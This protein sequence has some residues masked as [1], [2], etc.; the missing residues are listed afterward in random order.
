M[1]GL[2]SSF[3]LVRL[4][5]VGLLLVSLPLLAAI[6]TALVQLDGFAKEGQTALLNVQENA[7]QTRALSDRVLQMERTARQFVA[8]Q[9]ETYRSLFLEHAG[10]AESALQ[11][12]MVATEMETM[13]ALI[14]EISDHLELALGTI[15]RVDGQ[16]V[17]QWNAGLEQRFVD[18]RTAV[19]ALVQEQEAR[20]QSLASAMPEEASRLQTLLISL[21]VIVVPLSVVL[22]WGILVLITRPVEQLGKSIR[23][24]GQSNLGEPVAVTGAYDVEELGQRLEWLRLR[25]AELEAQK[26][27]FIRNVTHELKTP[28]SNI[29]E[30]AELLDD[31]TEGGRLGS[32][33]EQRAILS[34][35][36][37]NSVRLQR[38]IE[39]LLHFGADSDLD[40]RVVFS[41]VDLKALIEQQ[42][43]V[44]TSA[45]SARDVELHADLE[46]CT[47]HGSARRLQVIIDNL[48]SNAIKY[49][50]HGGRVHVRLRASASGGGTLEVEDTGPGV[51][52]A[53][54]ERLF[55]WFYTGAKP[56][57]ALVAGTGM[58]LAISAEYAAQHGGV[59][60]LV[61][62]TDEVGQGA[63]FRLTMTGADED[64]EK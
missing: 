18:L 64:A 45:R 9:D 1:R 63:R 56:K 46:A 32:E 36:R 31:G 8:L 23:A 10:Q 17:P 51:P 13:S 59:L 55:E 27:Q 5:L 62:G 57:D 24:L 49:T 40:D 47:V 25:L 37:N 58:G 43:A 60:E 11:G 38:M 16:S 29:R 54:R 33:E 50:P 28:L 52:P 44:H 12:L 22:G 35:L 3:T 19:V 41:P 20:A 26:S 34:I 48:L 14:K 30:A 61:N 4:V 2:I 21:A 42:I 7:V 53:D 15:E 39:Q 6:L